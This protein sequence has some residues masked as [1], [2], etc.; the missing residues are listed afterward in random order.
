[1][2]LNMSKI[3][4]LRVVTSDNALDWHMKNTLTRLNHDSDFEVCVVGDFVS[5]F[6]ND[7]ENIKF[8]DIPIKRKICL[9]NDIKSLVKLISIIFEF[10]PNIL[11]SIMPKA[12]LLSALA[13]FICRTKVRMH[14]FTGQYW[15]LNRLPFLKL[16]YWVDRLVCSLNTHPLTDGM[17]QAFF[18]RENGIN[19]FKSDEKPWLGEGSLSGVNLI[20][21]TTL[22]VPNIISNNAES[23]LFCFLARKVEE[24]GAFDVLHAFNNVKSKMPNSKLLYIGP[25]VDNV[26]YNYLKENKPHLFDKVIEIDQIKNPMSYLCNVDVICLP[27]YIEG[28]S[29]VV[30]EAGVFGKP[31][32]GYNIIGIRDSIAH[33]STGLL[34]EVGS[35]VGFSYNMLY[36]YE[37]KFE[38]SRIS[39]NVKKDFREKYN[40]DFLYNEL[41]NVYF[42][43]LLGNRK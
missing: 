3:R 37:N 10:K 12:S 16:M 11:H 21:R 30:I 38:Y 43:Y 17:S 29:S 25:I 28:F 1:M 2:W 7:Y 31:T 15:V 8:V 42:K 9:A 34:S 5:Q 35:V 18:L 32:V 4:L 39:S 36:L 6:S 22:D 14:T 33:L 41:K 26:Q 27:S 13:G 23:F 19:I 40:A 20:K 24:K